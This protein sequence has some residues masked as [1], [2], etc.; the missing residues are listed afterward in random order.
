MVP[1]GRKRRELSFIPAMDCRPLDLIVHFGAVEVELES[2]WMSTSLSCSS[3]RRSWS[4]DGRHR[5]RRRLVPSA[6]SKVDAGIELAHRLEEPVRRLGSGADRISGG[7]RRHAEPEARRGAG[8]AACQWSGAGARRP[9]ARSTRE[10]ARR[11]RRR[12]WAAAAPVEQENVGMRC[13]NER[14]V[15]AFYSFCAC[16]RGGLRG[17]SSWFRTLEPRTRILKR[18]PSASSRWRSFSQICRGHL[19]TA[20]G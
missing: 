10:A 9:A 19:W 20:R 14:H 2:R 16:G 3:N 1:A 13:A 15:L 12:G 18:M 6:E 5:R 11:R 8:P 4:S 17:G 7:S